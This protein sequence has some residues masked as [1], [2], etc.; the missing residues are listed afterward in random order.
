[1]SGVPSSPAR[2]L[3][4]R[5][6]PPPTPRDEGV[7]RHGRLLVTDESRPLP[8]RCVRCNRPAFGK[9]VQL[10]LRWHP[11]WAWLVPFILAMFVTRRTKV[12]FPVCIEHWVRRIVMLGAS[13][14]FVVVGFPI[15]IAGLVYM[16]DPMSLIGLGAVAASPVFGFIGWLRVRASRI[17]K[18][19]VW[20]KG[21]C[22]AYLNELPEWVDDKE[23][24]TRP[25]R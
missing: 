9:R 3:A 5:Y 4:V 1:M 20:I 10:T 16:N 21:V 11:W 2:V 18:T 25:I 12:S 24:G 15:L 19:T 8:D 23:K 7:W 14:V 13:A 6:V 17:E 22:A